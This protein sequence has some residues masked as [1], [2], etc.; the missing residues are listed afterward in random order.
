M[1]EQNQY[2]AEAPLMQINPYKE[3][4]SSADILVEISDITDRG[5]GSLFKGV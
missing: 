4:F 3:A 5:M 1:D 2:L